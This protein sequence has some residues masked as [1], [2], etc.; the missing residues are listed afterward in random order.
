VFQTVCLSWLWT[1]ILLISA[2]EQLESQ[3]WAISAQPPLTF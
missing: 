3:A 1:T 2:P